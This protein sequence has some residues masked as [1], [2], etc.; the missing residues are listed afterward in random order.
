MLV[1]YWHVWIMCFAAVWGIVAGKV[2]ALEGQS[3]H[4]AI[5]GAGYVGAGT[6]LLSGPPAALLLTLMVWLSSAAATRGDLW[7]TL[8]DFGA[9]L[10]WGPIG[11]AVGGLLI[12]IAVVL[13]GGPRRHSA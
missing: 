6:G 12:G 1:A 8:E 10:I 5:L 7:E 2:I 4:A 13:T 11:G 9:G 3:R